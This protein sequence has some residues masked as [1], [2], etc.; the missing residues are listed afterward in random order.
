ML[1]EAYLSHL[2]QHPG[3]PLRAIPFERCLADR[4]IYICLKNL[5]QIR[6]RKREAK[7]DASRPTLELT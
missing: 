1:H 3:S 5:A 7:Q 4:A 6:A 2:Q